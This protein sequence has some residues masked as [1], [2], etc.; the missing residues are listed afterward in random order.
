MKMPS[1]DPINDDAAPPSMSGFEFWGATIQPGKVVKCEIAENILHVTSIA[2]D[3]ANVDEKMAGQRSILYAVMDDKQ[4]V[5]ASLREGGCEQISVDFLFRE[6]KPFK[7]KLVGKLPVHLVGY[8]QPLMDLDDDSDDE[9]FEGSEEDISEEE[10]DEEM[11]D[12]ESGD[13]DVEAEDDEEESGEEDDEPVEKAA[14]SRAAGGQKRPNDVS[15]DKPQQIKKQKQQEKQQQQKQQQKP[16]QQKKEQEQP[17]KK[18]VAESPALAKKDAQQQQQ[19]QA[20]TPKQAEPS[21][22]EAPNKDGFVKVFGGVMIKDTKIGEGKVAAKGKRLGV[23][24]KGMLKNGKVFDSNTDSNKPFHF[25]LG[26]GDVI[27]AW[28]VGFAGMKVGGKRTIVCPPKMAYGKEGAPPA[29]PPNSVLIFEVE[30][31]HVK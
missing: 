24:Y 3:L 12:A 25:K 27:K 19:K 21:G 8:L 26:N 28:D 11:I 14:P 17:K 9:D 15:E 2:L 23:T 22:A 4:F 20:E 16:P 5:I 1:N 18:G 13:E 30:L 31:C 7:F 10:S 29:I 6:S